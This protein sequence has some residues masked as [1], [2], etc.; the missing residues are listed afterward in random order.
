M[1]LVGIW[2]AKKNRNGDWDAWTSKILRI[3]KKDKWF[4]DGSFKWISYSNQFDGYK[5]T[6]FQYYIFVFGGLDKLELL[7]T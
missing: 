5:N 6:D 3:E 1:R 7:A 4:N 2:R